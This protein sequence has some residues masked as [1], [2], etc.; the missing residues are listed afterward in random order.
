MPDSDLS[1]ARTA[2]QCDQE[3]EFREKLTLS[4]ADS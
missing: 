4:E 1:L 2:R 3:S